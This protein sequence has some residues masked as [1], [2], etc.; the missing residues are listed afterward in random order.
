MVKMVIEIMRENNNSRIYTSL[1]TRVLYF[2][3]PILNFSVLALHLS[4][5]RPVSCRQKGD[6]LSLLTL[7]TMSDFPDV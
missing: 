2:P 4:L 3:Y 7:Q 5:P 1:N 6:V